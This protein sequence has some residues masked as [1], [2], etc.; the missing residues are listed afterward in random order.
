MAV[1]RLRASELPASDPPL[2]FSLQFERR[3]F[4]NWPR[5]VAG[6]AIAACISCLAAGGPRPLMA[7]E[8]AKIR[9]RR[10]D[11]IVQ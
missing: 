4:A 11:P 1:N 7:T 9:A 3:G 6:S 8:L 5:C 2:R 10:A